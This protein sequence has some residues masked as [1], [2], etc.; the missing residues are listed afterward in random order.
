MSILSL[1]TSSSY[2][3]YFLA[4]KI[5]RRDLWC[6]YRQAGKQCEHIQ[7]LQLLGCS[8][9]GFDLQPSSGVG[10]LPVL[11]PLHE[12]LCPCW[13]RL[14]TAS[15]SSCLARKGKTQADNGSSADRRMPGLPHWQ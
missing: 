4:K 1:N 13:R 15:A 6:N 10:Q 8:R 5:P 11:W 12:G 9:S 2:T 14:A 3:K 7:H